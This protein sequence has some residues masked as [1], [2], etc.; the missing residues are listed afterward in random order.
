MNIAIILIAGN[1][2]RIHS[3]TPKQFILINDVPLFVYTT[4]IFNSCYEI[5]DIILVTKKEWINFVQDQVK[6]NDLNKVST[7]VEGGSSRQESVFKGL[8]SK[9]FSDNDIILIHDGARALV[10]ERIIIDNINACKEYSAVV[11]AIKNADTLFNYDKEVI[12]K[13]IP[14]DNV[15]RVQTPQT[16]K[17][18]I[19]KQAHV[20]NMHS[21]ASDDSSLVNMYWPVHVVSGDNKNF[22]IT[23]DDDI[24][25][26]RQIVQDKGV[27]N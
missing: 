9:N 21:N 19:I 18:K 10:S 15:Y 27:N 11:T 1:S 25:F 8:V 26:F 22:K 20:K 4:R 7:I 12:E 2:T 13:Y 3:D 24:S 6:R 5:D 23:T 14:R 16:F 17:Y